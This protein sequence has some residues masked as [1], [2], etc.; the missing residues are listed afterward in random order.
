M[1]SRPFRA[2]AALLAFLCSPVPALAVPVPLA[3][4]EGNDTAATAQTLA[5]GVFTDVSDPFAAFDPEV[6][7]STTIPH[8]TV[9]GRLGSAA[10]VDF[11]RFS[12]AAGSR[13]LFDIDRGYGGLQSVDLSLALFDAAGRVLAWGTAACQGACIGGAPLDP[14]SAD[15]RDPFI[16]EY[17]FSTAGSYTLAVMADGIVPDAFGTF[18]GTLGRPDGQYGGLAYLSDG[19]IAGLTGSPSSPS[20]GDYLLRVSLSAPTVVPAP[21]VLALLAGGLSLGVVFAGRR[22]GDACDG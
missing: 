6:F 1:Q 21:S 2:L 9:A 5:P 7:G 13:G 20:S 17:T 16:G 14:G 11:Y 12:V 10:D 19:G 8:V 22:R 4:V 18:A 3:E 15:W